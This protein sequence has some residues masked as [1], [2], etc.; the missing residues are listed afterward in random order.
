MDDK[1]NFL[2]EESP[3]EEAVTEESAEVEAQAEPEAEGT[4]TAEPEEAVAEAKAEGAE[5]DGETG[6]QEAS[7]PDAT[8]QEQPQTVP[9]SSLKD[10]REKRQA[11]E[12]RIAQMEAAGNQPQQKPDF[13]ENPQAAVQQAVL[14]TKMEQSRFLAER[15]FGAEAVREAIEFFNDPQFAPISHQLINH[16]SP[17]HAAVEFVKKQKLIQEMGDDPDAFINSRVEAELQK[18]LAAAPAQ[19]KAQ[20]A[21]PPSMAKASSAGRDAITQGSTFDSMFDN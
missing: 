13:F 17:M 2:D 8:G 15:E 12:Q 4:E 5:E 21:P 10:E 14:S 9:L 18:R 11:L 6:E 1:L 20:K 16:P 19:P 7:P 3:A